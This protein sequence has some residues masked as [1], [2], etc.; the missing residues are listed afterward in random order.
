MT[1]DGMTSWLAAQLTAPGAL[2]AVL[3]AA[4]VLAVLC[5]AVAQSGAARR[6]QLATDRREAEALAEL[7]D[8]ACDL[9]IAVADALR[10]EVNA[11][12]FAETFE[13]RQ[14]IDA[15]L[16]LDAIQPQSLPSVGLLRPLFELRW[17]LERSLELA[18]W[19]VDALQAPD[20][21]GWREAASETRSLAERAA[22]AADAFRQFAGTRR[23]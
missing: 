14:L 18:D 10:D 13:R 23:R 8:H 15:D 1:L 9:V 6:R 21:D 22:L 7:A 17:T 16:M 3:Q 2:V 4:S 5:W 11:H 19:L 12:D 20:R